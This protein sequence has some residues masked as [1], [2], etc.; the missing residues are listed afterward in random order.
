VTTTTRPSDG[1]GLRLLLVLA[2]LS[3][4]A[5]IATDLYLASFPEIKESLDTDA[6]HV[7]LTM[8]AYLVGIGIGQVL[9]GPVTDRFGRRRPLLAGSAVAVLAGAVAVAAPTVEVLVAARFVQALAAAAGM[10]ISRA[11]IADT[12]RGFAGA[13]SMSLLMSITSV[14][15]VIAPLIGGVLAG[16]VSWRGVLAVILGFMVLQVLGAVTTVPETLPPERRAPRL[17]YAVL[18]GRLRRPPFVAYV[19]TQSCA[20]G[21]L[22]AYIASSS[23]VYQQV[24]GTSSVVYGVGFAVNATGVMAAGMASARLTRHQVHPSLIVRRALPALLVSC[25]G[26]LAAALSPVPWLLVLPLFFATASIGFVSGNTAALAMEHTR[27]AVGAGSAV[28]GG[29]MFLVGGVVSP[30]GGLAGDDTAVP[31]ALVMLVSAGCSAV[32]FTAARRFVAREP[33]TEAAFTRA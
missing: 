31:M 15:P 12:V 11:V 20:F 7:Q 32:A 21:A 16:H 33:E 25:A 14:A 8:T 3:A 5:P 23:F 26:V 10:V 17:R 19:L 27:D 29:T 28:L 9:W 4:S 24:L 6:A 22:M 30:L 1:L 2:V 18:L 13:R